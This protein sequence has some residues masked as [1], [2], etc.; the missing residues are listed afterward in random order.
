MTAPEAIEYWFG[1]S[2]GTRGTY[3]D[4]R[5]HDL[6]RIASLIPAPRVLGVSR[7]GANV[8]AN[9]QPKRRAA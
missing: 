3:T 6:V 2:T 4:P 1:R 7:D 8:S 9:P 5:A